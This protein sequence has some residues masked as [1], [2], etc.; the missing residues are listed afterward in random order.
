[1][2]NVISDVCIPTFDGFYCLTMIFIGV[3]L[4][5]FIKCV[6]CNNFTVENNAILFYGYLNLMKL[7]YGLTRL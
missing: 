3:S 7:V 6:I 1:M 2:R 4:W 5:L